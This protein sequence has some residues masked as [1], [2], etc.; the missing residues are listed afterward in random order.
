MTYFGIAN[1]NYFENDLNVFPNI[2][3]KILLK[4]IKNNINYDISINYEEKVHLQ[5]VINY[6]AT[7]ILYQHRSNDSLKDI[8]KNINH[9]DIVT[10]RASKRSL[11]KDDKGVIVEKK[12]IEFDDDKHDKMI[13]LIT[14]TNNE[15]NVS[16]EKLQIGI[17]APNIVFNV[18]PNQPSYTVY[19]YIKRFNVELQCFEHYTCEIDGFVKSEINNQ[20]IYTPVEFKT[21]EILKKQQRLDIDDLWDGAKTSIAVQ[22]QLSEINNVIFGFRNNLSM[23]LK[24]GDIPTIINGLEYKV[25]N[26]FK[27]MERNTL[28]IIQQCKHSQDLSINDHQ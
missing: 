25:R 20:V 27:R 24:Y 10:N 6:D 9:G 22:C 15:I 8:W 18:L 11:T 2:S 28:K 4:N 19:R 12:W 23:K 14:K 1:L 5:N 3:E 16:I 21:M 13:Y 26:A 17:Y 7:P